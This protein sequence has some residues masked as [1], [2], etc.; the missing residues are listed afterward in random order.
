MLYKITIEN[1]FSIA[2]EQELVLAV[3]Q[4][5]PDLPCFRLP[6]SNEN[7]RLPVVL[8]F[9]GP[10]ASGKSTTLRAIVSSA[11]F[12]CLSFDWTEDQI[13]LFFQPYRQKNW[14]GKPT[15]ILIEFD[16][17][18]NE[19]APLTLFR[20]ELHIAHTANNFSNKVVSYE[21]LF[22]APK[23]K[24]RR[25]FERTNQEFHF[26]SEFGLSST[27]DPRRESI[28]PNASVISTLAKL[29]HPL[30]IYLRQQIGTVQTNIIGV[31][32]I[33]QN[34]NHWLS[35]Y[36]NNQ[37]C[38][39]RLNRELRRF[40]VGLESM[41]VEQGNHGLFAKFKHVGLDDFIFLPEES[42]GTQRFIEIFPRLHYAL[43][44]GSIAII[45]ELDT[46]L[47]P[48]LLPELFRWFEDK[49]RNLHGAQ[50][51]FTAH[52]PALL[53]CLEKEQ[54]FFTEKPSGQPSQVYGVRAIQGLRREPSLMKKYLMGELG[55]VPHVG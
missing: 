25:L 18:L 41:L 50:L 48:L 21:A 29:N 1:F 14:W 15:K 12:A 10:N 36:A 3:P 40:D 46:D 54:I 38:L 27:N 19:T 26:G 37:S 24:F 51:F 8:G 30:S 42:A 49:E 6:Y 5:A 43:E 17:R 34:A 28:R 55:A 53:D 47:H 31:N 33:Q 52:N 45:D 13:S 23:G 9:F 35:A 32:K 7:V 11:M 44:T 22:Y 16:A 20:Y 2:N 39:D 4:K